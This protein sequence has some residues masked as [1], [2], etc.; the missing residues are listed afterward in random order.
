M[1]IQTWCMKKLNTGTLTATAIGRHGVRVERPG[2]PDVVAYCPDSGSAPFT[3]DDLDAALEEVEGVQAL[4][5]VRRPLE[6][7]VFHE[8]GSRGLLVATFGHF[9]QALG[10]RDVSTF[11]HSEETYLHERLDPRPQVLRVTRIGI[12]AWRIDRTGDLRTLQ[13]VTHDRYE[14]TDDE[15]WELVAQNPGLNTD[16]FVITNP[17]SEGFGN[18]VATSAEGLG[19]VICT[20]N[21]FLARL[22]QRWT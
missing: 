3:H 17:N 15:M 5:V 9:E 20:M 18:R 2:K 6:A 7:G 13:I 19:I 10:K 12:R 16:A 4:V 14:F 11:V 1:S 8:A 21:E 22:G